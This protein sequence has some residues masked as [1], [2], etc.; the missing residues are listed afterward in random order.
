MTEECYQS[1]PQYTPLMPC[2]AQITGITDNCLRV[3]G[4]CFVRISDVLTQFYVVPSMEQPC[5]L[6]MNFIKDA[7]ATVDVPQ[8]LLHTANGKKYNLNFEKSAKGIMK[9]A[10]CLPRAPQEC[11]NKVI[12][13]YQD[14]FSHKE[15]PVKESSLPP[16]VID[17]GPHEPIRQ[18]AYRLPLKKREEVEKCVNTML[19]DGV[20]QP[21]SSPWSSPI[22]LVPKKDGTTRFCIDYRQLNSITHKD[23][24]PLPN[25]QDVFDSL[26]GATI[27]STLDLK[28]GYW[29]MPMH[30]DS[31]AKTAFTCHLGLFEFTRLPFGL[32]NAPAIFQREVSKALSGLL[33][34]VCLVY[35]DDIVVFSQTPEQHAKDLEIVFSHL[36]KVG[37]QVKASKCDFG[38]DQIE[39]LVYLVS[40]DGIAALPSRVDVILKLEPPTD[41]KGIRSFLGLTGYYR[42]LI[43]DYAVIAY[44]L[45][46]LTKKEQPYVWTPECQIAFDKLKQALA[47]ESV[48][49]H[50]VP[51]RPYV[52][53]TDVSNYAI[54]AVL[55]QTDDFGKEKVI[56]YL[57]HKL[58][59]TQQK[60]A[61]IEKEAYAIVY[62]LKKFH[63]YLHGAEFRIKTDHKLLKSLFQ[64]EIRNTKLQRWAIKLVNM[65]PLLSTTQVK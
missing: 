34:K 5:L 47:Q 55:S 46:E 45:T 24:H 12:Q 4:K 25:I 62:A 16:A 64:S 38:K 18:R 11:I 7:G 30:K 59:E 41:K 56:S 49:S 19:Q 63:A 27:F 40:K 14:I 6:G 57:S 39:L 33:G 15:T 10:I 53:R 17:T 3:K 22:T 51:S 37:L 1:L 50:P 2:R 35:I 32:T 23:A 26:S 29:Q 48:L 31:I 28:S 44:P 43:E 61:T 21:S 54:G 42:Q 9:T 13:V 60:W 36:K 52:L 8:K 20:I 58:S 65:A